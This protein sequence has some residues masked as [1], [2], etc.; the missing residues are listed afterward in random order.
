[1]EEATTYIMGACVQRLQ[2]TKGKRSKGQALVAAFARSWFHEYQTAISYPQSCTHLKGCP[3][4]CTHL[5]ERNTTTVALHLQPRPW[6]CVLLTLF[7]RL[8]VLLN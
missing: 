3:L 4:I 2:H 6:L 7:P 5:R 8:L 1:M